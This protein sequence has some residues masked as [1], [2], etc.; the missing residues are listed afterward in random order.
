MYF[1]FLCCRYQHSTGREAVLEMLHAI[2]KKFP[3]HI[4]N[5]KSEILFVRLVVC[6]ANDSDHQVRSMTGAAIKILVERVDSESLHSILVC[7]FAW[8]SGKEQGNWS[9]AAQVLS[10]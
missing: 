8:Y 1:F 4:V 6:L 5:G 9:V 2:I 7:T 3:S 10:I